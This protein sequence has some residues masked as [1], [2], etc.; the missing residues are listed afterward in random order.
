MRPM[1]SW[2][3]FDVGNV[4]LNDDPAQARAF[5]LLHRALVER[6][7]ALSFAD[8]LAERRALFEEQG[9][10]PTRPYFQTLGKKHL[11]PE[12]RQVLA[13]MAAE[14]FSRW[15]ELSPL[16]PGIPEVIRSLAGPYRLGIIA[17]QPREVVPVLKAHALW[18]HF[19]VHG[20]SSEV[21]L[22]K[23]DARFFQ[24]ALG[25]AGS[26]PEEALMI[27]DRLDNDI[28]PARAMG[29]QTLHLVLDPAGKGYEP[30]DDLEKAYMAE[31]IAGFRRPTPP[32]SG[33][34]EATVTV[35]R[36]EEIPR[37][38]ARLAAETRGG[39]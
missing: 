16:L 36:V 19:E 18:D 35:Y 38:I 33:E 7:H 11:G 29:M 10:E 34:G 9:Q 28:L 22:L 2:I 17:N 1:L 32:L 24:W 25:Q 39:S 13:G 8:L 12:Y 20:I 5:V 3:F 6:G 31:R 30:E 15:G 23:P 37:A 27:G 26:A 4:I 21:G 14:I